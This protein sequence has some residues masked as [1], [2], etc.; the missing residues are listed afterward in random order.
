MTSTA[1]TTS[2]RDALRAGLS[3]VSEVW[4]YKAKD[5]VTSVHAADIDNDGDLEII[6]CSRD[7]RVRAFDK[8]GKLLWERVIGSKAWVGAIVGIQGD[9]ES[10]E[11]VLAGT[12]DG[13]VYAFAH[14][15]RT[16][17]RNGALY[18]YDR[19]GY[20][21]NQKDEKAACLL[22]TNAVIR[23]LSPGPDAASEV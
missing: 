20:A 15:G 3:V 18:A 12:H 9:K 21:V 7:G 5:W 2:F 14:N 16:V 6:S 23:Q 17:G 13:K 1:Q 10:R 22:D 4:S 8:E 11:R 19:N